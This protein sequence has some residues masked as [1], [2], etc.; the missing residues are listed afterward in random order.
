LDLD[1][2]DVVVAETV[3][4]EAEVINLTGATVESASG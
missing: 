3:A 1:I 4:A 2:S